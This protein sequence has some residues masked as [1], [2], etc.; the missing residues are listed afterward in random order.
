M[1]SI[2]TL[3]SYPSSLLNALKGSIE[4]LGVDVVDLYQIHGPIHLRSVEVVADA[5]AEAFKLG[6]VKSVG[7]S[8]YSIDQ[9]VRMHAALAKHGIQLASNQVEFSLLRRYPETSGLIAKCHELGVAVLAYSPLGM[10]RLTGKYT[11][12]NPPPSGRRFS[13]YPMTELTPLLTVI[14]RI[15][16]EHDVPMSAG[17][18]ANTLP[19]DMQ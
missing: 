18:W 1:F 16:K 13:N 6:L 15:A 17:K 4:R 5:L 2:P 8:N 11:A 3:Y 19:S 9:M 12:E 14:E 7:V 10:G